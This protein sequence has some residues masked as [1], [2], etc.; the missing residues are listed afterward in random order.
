MVPVDAIEHEQRAGGAQVKQHQEGDESR[1]RLLELP[2]EQAR[3][4]HRVAERRN[5]EQLGRALEQAHEER[6]RKSHL[7]GQFLERFAKQAAR[8][9]ELAV[10]G[11]VF[12]AL[13]DRDDV[14]PA[15]WVAFMERGSHLPDRLRREK[16]PAAWVVQ[17]LAS[18]LELASSPRDDLVAGMRLQGFRAKNLHVD[19]IVQQAWR[20][21]RR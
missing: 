17:D 10:D 11:Q 13:E 16:E 20:A 1:V 2:V 7:S 4:D 5:R 9:L 12:R 8:L 15:F 19:L 3:D 21:P 14:L 18:Q 6:L